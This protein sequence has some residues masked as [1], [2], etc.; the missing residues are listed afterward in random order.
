MKRYVNECS[1]LVEYANDP[2]S[3]V[4]TRSYHYF[5]TPLDFICLRMLSS[6]PTMGPVL[7]CLG[8]AF[9]DSRPPTSSSFGHAVEL[10]SDWYDNTE[11]TDQKQFAEQRSFSRQSFV[12]YPDQAEPTE[13]QFSTVVNSI[14]DQ[15]DCDIQRLL[16][17]L[18][19]YRD[20]DRPQ[21]KLRRSGLVNSCE[22]TEDQ[23]PPDIVVEFARARI[24]HPAFLV[25]KGL[26]LQIG[27]YFVC[28]IFLDGEFTS[29]CAAAAGTEA[30]MFPDL[31][32]A[33]LRWFTDYTSNNLRLPAHPNSL[34]RRVVSEEIVKERFR[35]NCSRALEIIQSSTD[36]ASSDA[37]TPPESVTTSPSSVPQRCIRRSQSHPT[38]GTARTTSSTGHSRPPTPH[39]PSSSCCPQ[40]F[41]TINFNINTLDVVFLVLRGDRPG[42]YFTIAEYLSACGEHPK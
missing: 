25:C 20:I 29:S 37:P 12:A 2:N 8:G 30:L 38:P 7:S 24:D 31:Q 19:Q 34:F 32:S 28:G 23:P 1:L 35:A 6:P 15:R 18:A 11:S 13:C 14:S 9:Q 10:A 33:W 36:T 21:T 5:N 26:D 22:R 4:R 16:N 17:K 3:S 39:S 41:P 42:L 27:R 40:P